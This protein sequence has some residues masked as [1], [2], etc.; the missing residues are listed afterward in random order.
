M[1]CSD[2]IRKRIERLRKSNDPMAMFAMG[3][4]IDLLSEVIWEMED[5]K[6]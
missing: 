2:I 6:K 3:I 5:Q 4:L 1:T